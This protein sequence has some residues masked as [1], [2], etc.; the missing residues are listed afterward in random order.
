LPGEVDDPVEEAIPSAE[1]VPR[2]EDY[3]EDHP[4]LAGVGISFNTLVLVFEMGTT[5]GEANEL[6]RT[7]GPRSW[8]ASPAWWARPRASCSCGCRP[9]ITR[10]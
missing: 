5:V 10:R 9:P 3:S 1:F 7:S 8:A 4:D 2:E 6:L